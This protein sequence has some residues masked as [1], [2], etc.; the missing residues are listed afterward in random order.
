MQ[1]DLNK[2]HTFTAIAQHGGVTAAARELAL[3]PSAVSQSLTALEHSLELRLFN[4]AGRKLLLTRE[5][6]LLYRHF[7]ELE[8]QLAETLDEIANPEGAVRGLV[9]VGVFLGFPRPRLTRLL[10]EVGERHPEVSVKL[11]Y[12]SRGELNAGLISNRLDFV[13]SQDPE[14]AQTRRITSTRLFRH[15]LAL[16][17]NRRWRR[18]LEPFAVDALADVPIVDYYQAEPLIQRWIVHHTRKRPPRL[19]VRTWAATTDLVLDLV[20]AGTGIGVLPLHLVRSHV[21]R[22]RLFVVRGSRRP[23]VDDIWLREPRGAYRGPALEAFRSA[24]LETL[25]SDGGEAESP[26]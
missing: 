24:A 2:L 26:R 20:L 14:P 11:L 6:R 25:A 15:E 19:G 18:A 9:R 8:R 1:I 13:L 21:E 3:T 12:A 10:G 22:R 4:R 5:G 7:H 23:L 17:A 16:V